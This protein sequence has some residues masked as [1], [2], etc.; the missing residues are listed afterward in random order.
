[1]HLAFRNQNRSS[2]NKKSG[3]G[4]RTRYEFHFPW[5]EKFATSDNPVHYEKTEEVY[6][7]ESNNLLLMY[8][9]S[10]PFGKGL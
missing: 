1:M 9:T 3:T 10:C 7:W 6:V 8:N 5:F 2:R 4:G